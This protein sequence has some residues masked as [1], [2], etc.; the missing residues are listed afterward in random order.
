MADPQ[1]HDM[2]SLHPLAGVQINHKD[3]FL[4]QGKGL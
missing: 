1:Q 4:L 3:H 2:A